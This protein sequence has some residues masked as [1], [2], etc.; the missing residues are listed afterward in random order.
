MSQRK[1]KFQSVLKREQIEQL[2]QRFYLDVRRDAQI[3]RVFERALAGRW[4]AHLA[5]MAD[6]WCTVML[7]SREF[8]GNVFGKHMALGRLSESQYAR[9]L[10]LWHEH[11]DALF[12]PEVAQ[13]LTPASCAWLRAQSVLWPPPAVRR[14]RR[15]QRRRRRLPPA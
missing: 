1:T 6:F 4:H 15:A 11:S 13:Q 10:T 12:P 5:R 2:V 14:V 7:G 3:G 8:R 9:W